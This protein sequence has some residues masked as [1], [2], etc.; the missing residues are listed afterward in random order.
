MFLK[1]KGSLRGIQPRHFC[2]SAYNALTARPNRL[3]TGMYGLT[4]RYIV[5]V[6]K[7]R[8]RMYHSENDPCGL[9]TA[10]RTGY[11]IGHGIIC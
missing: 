4:G 3:T 5:C 9:R 6:D 8:Y 7:G 10:K 2:L 11:E 1:R